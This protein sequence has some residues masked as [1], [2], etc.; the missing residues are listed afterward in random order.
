MRSCLT[1]L[2][3]FSSLFFFTIHSTEATTVNE[4]QN[5]IDD[6]QHGEIIYLDN[7]V[8]RGPVTISKPL[9]IIGQEQTIIEG[10]GKQ[11]VVTIQADNVTIQSVTIKQSGKGKQQAGI[12]IDKVNRSTLE[13]I[14]FQQVQNGIFIRGGKGHRLTKNNIESY[15]GHFSKRG[16]GIHLLATEAVRVTA[17]EMVAVQDGI[18]LDDATDTLIEKNSVRDSRYG[19]H[20]MFSKDAQARSNQ[21]SDNI[22]GVMA[23]NSERI[24]MTHNRFER[25]LNYRGYGILIYEMKDVDVHHNELYYNH[26]AVEIQSS[27][28]IRIGDN[29][30]G[31]NT[32]GFAT[33]GK[34]KAIQFYGNEMVGNIVQTRLSGAPIQM[35]GNEW[36]DYHSYDINGDGV[37]EIPYETYS[38]TSE[39]VQRYPHLQF[40]FESPAM[41]IWQSIEKM[42]SVSDTEKNRDH[43]PIVK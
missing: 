19:I 33:S 4:L 5:R 37:G 1:G 14:T 28:H 9:T 25:Q 38:A 16:N 2:L 7:Q 6:A 23:M 31:G 34:N 11:D 42:F 35:D 17:N 41:S 8:Y 32:V 21:F 20:F 40:F 22:N 43:Q 13:H 3:L 39:W 18:Y 10:D 27:E 30:F 26:N 29:T 15:D 12:L 36:D 24:Q